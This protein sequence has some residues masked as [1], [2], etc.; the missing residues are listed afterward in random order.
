METTQGNTTQANPIPVEVLSAMPESE[1][2]PKGPVGKDYSQAGREAGQ[3]IIAA[4]QGIVVAEMSLVQTKITKMQELT[5]LSEVERSTY[6]GGLDNAFIMADGDKKTKGHQN[7]LAD[8]R[9]IHFALK[10]TDPKQIVDTLNGKGTYAEKM[11]K[12]PKASARGGSNQGT[13][14]SAVV[15]AAVAAAQ[16]HG[17]ENVVVGKAGEAAPLSEAPKVPE[18]KTAPETMARDALVKGIMFAHENDLEAIGA[19]WANRMKKSTNTDYQNIGATVL[20]LLDRS[21]EEVQTAQSVEHPAAKI[22]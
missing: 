3:A 5:T 13:G 2:N 17:P 21:T 4:E 7:I 11:E 12:I 9:R 10:V 19:A 22:A 8:F 15:K 14:T 1:R 6:I 16:E 18:G 20:D